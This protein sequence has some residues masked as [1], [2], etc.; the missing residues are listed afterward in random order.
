MKQY[1]RTII[2]GV[3]ARKEQK[4]LIQ[5]RGCWLDVVKWDACKLIYITMPKT[6]NTSIKTS[7]S[8]ATGI[9]DQGDEAA[10][11]QDPQKIHGILR[12]KHEVT[13]NIE[14]ISSYPDYFVF[15]TVRNPMDRFISFYK[16][17]VL[18]GGWG[19]AKTAEILNTYG[20]SLESSNEKNISKI[21]SFS[22]QLSEIHFRSQYGVLS[23]HGRYLPHAVFRFEQMD[24]MWDILRAYMSQQGV[25]LP[26][27]QEHI[28]KSSG[29]KRPEWLTPEIEAMIQ[30]RHAKDF[31]F[32]G[33]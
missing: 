24:L 13:L 2:R 8:R 18:G 28:N 30:A 15:S 25:A 27:S 26:S 31:R 12:S 23:H 22:D 11:A 5:K 9:L 20:I 1:F 10:L 33:Y 17:K 32:F 7:I 29:S 3:R 6:A 19:E 4:R 16:D 21:C 14:D